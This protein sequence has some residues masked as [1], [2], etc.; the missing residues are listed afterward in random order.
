MFCW[1]VLPLIEPIIKLKSGK[2]IL[3]KY[4]NVSSDADLEEV[5]TS[6]RK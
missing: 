4:H 2:P 1:E 5:R 3:N 6:K